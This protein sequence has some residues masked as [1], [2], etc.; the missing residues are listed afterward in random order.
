MILTPQA[1]RLVAEAVRELPGAARDKWRSW[2]EC[3]NGG[4][5]PEELAP[6]VLDALDLFMKRINARLATPSLS[7]DDQM[8][9]TN[10]LGYVQAIFGQLRHEAT[11][12]LRRRA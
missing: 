10:E 8:D 6:V 9:L 12:A 7:E 2:S 3:H 1:Q 5:L 11:G 4:T